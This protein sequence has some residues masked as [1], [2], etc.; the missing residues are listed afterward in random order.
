MDAGCFHENYVGDLRYF[1]VIY[2]CRKRALSTCDQ[3]ASRCT[4]SPRLSHCF[5]ADGRGVNDA[6]NG[7]AAFRTS[8][9]LVDGWTW[10]R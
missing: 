10:C 4:E 1:A 6:I 2:V 5:S 9:F 3:V 8:R 7:A